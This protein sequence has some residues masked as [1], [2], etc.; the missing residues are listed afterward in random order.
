M[1]ERH[2]SV[3]DPYFSAASRKIAFWLRELCFD[4]AEEY[5]FGP[6]SIDIY[7]P[8]LHVGVEVDGPHHLKSRDEK[9]DKILMDRFSLPIIRISHHFA[10]ESFDV[11]GPGLWDLLKPYQETANDRLSQFELACAE[12]MYEC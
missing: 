6:F 12:L 4:T 5:E 8:S 3:P 9:R 11:A 10:K 2:D 1:R 7:L